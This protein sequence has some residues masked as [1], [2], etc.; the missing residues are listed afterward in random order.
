MND[1]NESSKK[2]DDYFEDE[3]SLTYEEYTVNTNSQ[4]PNLTLKIPALCERHRLMLLPFIQKKYLKTQEGNPQSFLG[5]IVRLNDQKGSAYP[6][7]I[8]MKVSKAGELIILTNNQMREGHVVWRLPH[9]VTVHDEFQFNVLPDPLYN[10]PT[11]DAA[12]KCKY[13][14]KMKRYQEQSSKRPRESEDDDEDDDD[15]VDPLCGSGCQFSEE[16]MAPV[17]PIRDHDSVQYFGESPLKKDDWNTA[18]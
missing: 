6:S 15:G 11:F 12:V 13:D 7:G 18:L 16:C 4:V 17:A 14:M 9:E 3:E 8:V 2:Q 1:T 10:N 5:F